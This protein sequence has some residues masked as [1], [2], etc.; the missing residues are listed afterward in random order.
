MERTYERNDAALNEGLTDNLTADS[1]GGFNV[2]EGYVELNL[3]FVRHSGPFLDEISVDMAYRGSHYST[4]GQT[5][6]DKIS[7]IYAPASWFKFRGTFSEAVR[8]PNITEAYSPKSPTYFN[9]TDPCSTEN[10][11]QNVNYAKNCAAAGLPAGFTANTNASITGQSSGNPDLGTEKSLSYTGGIV[12]QPPIIPHLSITADYYSILIKDA[13]TE[14]AAQDIINNCYNG[15]AGLSDQYC[16]LFT[17]SAASNNINF[18]TT[19]YVNAAK[20]Y[21]KGVAL[22]LDYQTP[23]SRVT[24]RWRYSSWLTGRLGLNLD[25]NY[26]MRLRN[27]PFQNDPSQYNIWEGALSATEGDVPNMRGIANITYAQGAVHVDWRIRYIGRAARFDKDPTQT[28][29][30]EFQDQ[31]YAGAKTYHDITV[32]YDLPGALRG[33]QL[34]VGCND[35]FGDQPPLGLVDAGGFSFNANYSS[36]YDLGRYVFG[37]V[38]IQR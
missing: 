20:L 27:Y 1:A 37:G 3:P 24:S 7:A 32:R 29:F 22:Q 17:R 4:V 30:V 23:V 25:A 8:A 13:I 11:T 2:A 38:R 12:F 34:Y 31:S 16:S 33:V 28:E 21:E 10:I 35:L 18:I 14:V 5:S 6:A 15:S 36:G 9:I 26:I 19:T